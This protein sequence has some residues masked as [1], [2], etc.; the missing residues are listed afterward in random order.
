MRPRGGLC[1]LGWL[2]IAA[3]HQAPVRIAP[4]P[5]QELV[6]ARAAFR[7]GDF[8]KALQF[9]QRLIFEVGPNDSLAPEVH[10]SLAESYFQTGDHV[11]AAHEF[12]QVADQFPTSAYASAA[13]LRAGDANL[14]MW[15]RPDLDPTYGE[16]ALAI[17][18]ELTGRYPDS[19]SARRAQ[20]HVRQ[21]R[22]WFADKGY[23]NGMFYFRRKAWDSA[24]IY[25]KDVYASYPETPQAA[26]ALFRLADSYQAINYHEELREVCNTLQRY[27]RDHPGLA[28]RCPAAPAAVAPSPTP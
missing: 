28:R 5:D 1:L 10:Y 4:T 12:R 20:L 7:R 15:R 19:Q 26:D 22:E 23:R 11:Q 27:H 17:Y 14:R 2:A 18:Q 9:Y 24:I 3:C 25:F 21:L 8:S 16:A 6:A 13:L